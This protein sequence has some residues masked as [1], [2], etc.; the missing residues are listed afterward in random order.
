MSEP[1]EQPPDVKHT[2]AEIYL[3]PLVFMDDQLSKSVP[4][5]F[6]SDPFHTSQ[7]EKKCY[8]NALPYDTGKRA[9]ET[10]TLLVHALISGS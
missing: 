6:F 3:G 5:N 7:P 10:R 8:E 1:L 9:G 2:S 4:K